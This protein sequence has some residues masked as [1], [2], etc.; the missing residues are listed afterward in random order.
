MR[1]PFMVLAAIAALFTNPAFAQTTGTQT[2][3]AT[4][5]NT[6]NVTAV[7]QG[8]SGPQRN[9]VDYSGHTWTTPAVA[10]SYFGGTN[11]CLV[12]TGGG[13][14]GGPIGFSL[15]I[16]KSDKG[17]T[18]RSDAAAWHAM[19]FDNVAIA[20][21]C[22]D[23]ENADSFFSATG[24]A[25]PGTRGSRYKLAD[26]SEAQE[27]TLVSN[28]RAIPNNPHGPDA[29]LNMNDPRVRSQIREA[30]LQMIRQNPEA[31]LAA[32]K[33]EPLGQ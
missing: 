6:V 13:A 14:A 25:C 10:G 4:A 8:P 24:L 5:A 27:A 28:S 2:T 17:C 21:M 15:N 9:D 33:E 12:G 29:G 3:D 31:A 20:R 11:P 1:K 30:A 18:R 23:Q 26:G 7:A 16:G 19:G 32:A 22:Q